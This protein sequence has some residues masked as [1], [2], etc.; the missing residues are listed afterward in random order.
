MKRVGLFGG[1]FNPVHLGHLLAAQAAKEELGLE[2]VFFIPAAVS[3]FKPDR[4]LAPGTVRLQLLRLALAGRS[5][6]EVDDQEIQ[7]GGISYSID[8]VR[9]Y[10]ARFGGAAL[11]YLV[12]ADQAPLLPKWREAEELA[13]LVEIAIIPRRGASS[14]P[15]PFRSVVLRGIPFEVSASEIRTRVQAGLAIDLLTPASVV[16]AIRNNR[17]YL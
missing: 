4:E 8:T 12:G 15:P 6:A 5:Y 3:P 17:L 10:A 2:R 7:R 16:Q 14:A 13:R 11:F 1:S 9:S